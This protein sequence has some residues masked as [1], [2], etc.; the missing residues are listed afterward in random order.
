MLWNPHKLYCLIHFEYEKNF[1]FAELVK[2]WWF[3]PD[4]FWLKPNRPYPLKHL[5]ELIK[6]LGSMLS[7]FYGLENC[8]EFKLEWTP[9]VHHIITHG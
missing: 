3:D 2:S 4:I 6:L 5:R 9:L 7:M 8:I 1:E